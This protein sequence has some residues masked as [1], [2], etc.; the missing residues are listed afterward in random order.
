MRYLFLALITLLT[1]CGGDA[2]FI[3]PY[4]VTGEPV[5][6]TCNPDGIQP[7]DKFNE[8]WQV[9]EADLE[10]NNMGHL[11]SMFRDEEPNTVL[12]SSDGELF[13]VSY[14][15]EFFGCRLVYKYT[16]KVKFKTTKK[17]QTMVGPYSFEFSA[18]GTCGPVECDASWDLYGY[19]KL[20]R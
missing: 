18:D 4:N 6:N 12:R 1:A 2:P 3:G 19:R 8:I 17:R 16:A 7:G 9:M 10:E 13:K 14:T 20:E 11:Y 15:Y 5:V